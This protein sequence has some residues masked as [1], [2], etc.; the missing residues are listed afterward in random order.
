[1]E[2]RAAQL[3][4]SK[5]NFCSPPAQEIEIILFFFCIPISKKKVPAPLCAWSGGRDRSEPGWPSWM[6]AEKT[7]KTSF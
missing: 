3:K 6:L 7:Q 2:M 5:F 4:M 1:M